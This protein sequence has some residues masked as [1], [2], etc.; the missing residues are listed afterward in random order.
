MQAVTVVNLYTKSLQ[1][2]QLPNGM[3]SVDDPNTKL[4]F[5]GLLL[6]SLCPSVSSYHLAT[7]LSLKDGNQHFDF[8]VFRL[9][10][11]GEI[12]PEVAYSKWLVSKTFFFFPIEGVRA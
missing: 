2:L 3:F 4:G 1:R 7:F 12:D 11:N 6:P 10:E 5:L 9:W 8:C